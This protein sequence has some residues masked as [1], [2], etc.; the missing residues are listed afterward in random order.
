MKHMKL[1]T[2]CVV[3][4]QKFFSFFKTKTVQVTIN[5]TS[6]DIVNRCKSLF[7]LKSTENSNDQ[8]IISDYQLWLKTNNNEPLIPLIGNYTF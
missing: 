8:K 7:N 6:Q 5:E 1:I 2:H 4:K 3:F